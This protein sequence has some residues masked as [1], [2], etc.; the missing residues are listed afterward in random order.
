MKMKKFI[1]R[2][3]IVLLLTL[4]LGVSF[5]VSAAR[6]QGGG[7]MYDSK[8]QLIE[9]SVGYT[10]TEENIFNIL[11]DSWKK[12]FEKDGTIFN[13]PSDLFLFKDKETEEEIIY[14]T[15]SASNKLF[16]FDESLNYQSTIDTFEVDPSEFSIVELSVINTSTDNKTTSKFWNETNSTN[17]ANVKENWDEI[18]KIPFEEREETQKFFIKC[19]SL[20]GVYRSERPMRD[21]AGKIL[22]DEKGLTRY[23]KVLYLCDAGNK[24]IV[25]VDAETYKVKQI[26]SDPGIFKNESGEAV[27]FAP[28]KMVIDSMGRMYVIAQ[29]IY[30][31]ILLMNYD[32]TFM[33]Y[34]GVNYTTLSFWDALKRSRKT[35]EQLAQETTILPTSFTNLAIDADGFLYTVSG[36]SKNADGSYNTDSMIKKIN[37]TNS[38]VLKKNGYS[39]PIGDLITIKTG[40]NAGTSSF[41]AITINDFGVYTVADSKG[42]RL[43]T[44]DN[45]GNLLYISGGSGNQITD[46]KNPVAIAYQGENILVLDKLN[47]C[48]MRY[49][50]TEFAQNINKAV[51]YEYIG[52]STRAADEWQNVINRNKSYELAYVGVG[53]KFYD[54]KRYL[55]A[56]E[57]FKNGA[58]VKYFSRAYKLYR[59]DIIAEYVPIVLSLGLVA[60]GAAVVL[61][62]VKKF[63]GKNPKIEDG[64]L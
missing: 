40:A 41:V 6:G 38:D 27:A 16:I 18:S 8:G 53:K 54:E 55:D 63:K 62:V 17:W 14:I 22:L 23:E 4:C 11:S 31:G 45:E 52:D 21:E 46:I 44:Y 56:M 9:S 1:K 57:Y 2:F 58:D 36:P 33:T 29:N 34:Y 60:V 32:G 59:D 12:G 51:Y 7:Y 19:L 43:F 64:E 25:V 13:S 24:Q 49:T 20:S 10:V 39:K 47:K 30:Q 50:P 28:T 15:D 48:V 26:V 3:L 35:E 37:S 61:K 5:N 42:N